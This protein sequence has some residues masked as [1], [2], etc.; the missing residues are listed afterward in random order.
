MSPTKRVVAD[1]NPVLPPDKGAVLPACSGPN[2]RTNPEF[3]IPLRRP[4]L[5][6]SMGDVVALANEGIDVPPLLVPT[7]SCVKPTKVIA[8]VALDCRFEQTWQLQRLT[9]GDLSS[10]I[11]LAPGEQLTLEFQT[12]Q[13]KLM[14]RS[15]L[16][17]AESVDATEST[18][19]DTEAV[20][21]SRAATKTENW[22]VDTTGTLTCGYASLTVSG[23]Y[24]HSVTTSNQQ[25]INKV[26]AATRRS[27]HS[28]KTMHK[29]EVRGVTETIVQSRM[30]RTIENPYRDRTLSINV[31]QLLKH[32]RVTTALAET[33]L[34][35]VL[36][37]DGLVFDGAFVI[38]NVGFLRNTLL[39]ADL[40]DALPTAVLAASPRVDQTALDA[41]ALI[42][43]NALSELFDNKNIFNLPNDEPPRDDNDPETS[44]DGSPQSPTTHKLSAFATA[45]NNGIIQVFSTLALYHARYRDPSAVHWTGAQR[46]AF[47][48]ALA[49]EVTSYWSKVFP[50]S[51]GGAAPD[52][53]AIMDITNWNE[54]Y[55]RIFGYLAMIDGMLAPLLAEVKAVED[56]VAAQRAASPVLDRL[57]RHLNCNNK[58]YTQEF[59]RY[60]SEQTHGQAIVD[61]VKMCLGVLIARGHI[62]SQVDL[63]TLDIDAVVIDKTQ[64]IV[65]G[66]APLTPTEIG[67]LGSLVD[68]PSGP[69]ADPVPV[70][71]NL[72]VPA[73]GIHLEAVVGACVLKELPRPADCSFTLSLD[74]LNLQLRRNKA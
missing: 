66:A 65:S 39:D 9:I 12:S 15:V 18:Q 51:G 31:Y 6:F 8:N 58:Y 20:N 54:I 45:V 7:I 36:D 53:H 32:F 63:P 40:I 24:A 17:S 2:L 72:E 28:L 41:A 71:V 68:Q 52:W 60:M 61:L 19:S 59:L 50:D 43:Q 49:S 1:P 34:A 16:D 30:T 42:A 11:G 56:A 27:A 73:D 21:V 10:T 14:D 57:I 22:H 29:I 25:S 46:I 64:V 26:T 33:R 67:Q 38:E 70:P 37:L 55:R 69:V 13:R 48:A 35:I 4:I 5:V 47:A 74:D 62:P 44:F 3:V 23:G